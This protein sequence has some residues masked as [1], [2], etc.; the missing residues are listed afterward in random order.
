MFGYVEKFFPEVVERIRRLPAAI[1]VALVLLLAVSPLVAS[2]AA[3]AS[4]T[5]ASLLG[6]RYSL[7]GSVILFSAVA[8][9]VTVPVALLL[10]NILRSRSTL[11]TFCRQWTHFDGHFSLLYLRIE[12]YLLRDKN[13][14]SGFDSPEWQEIEPML[15]EYSRL[16]GRLRKLLFLL[17]EGRLIIRRVPAWE[18]LCRKNPVLTE[19]GYR[20]PFSFLLSLGNPIA[21]VNLDGQTVWSALHTAKEYLELLSYKNRALHKAVAEVRKSESANIR[22]GGTKPFPSWRLTRAW[23]RRRGKRAAAHAQAVSRI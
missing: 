11:V 10:I 6:Q 17:D 16:R 13:S 20:T 8:F 15:P 23:S 5:V 18:Q 14:G 7:S 22:Q 9:L 12:V 3:A 4:A 19:N 21:A 1:K 2:H